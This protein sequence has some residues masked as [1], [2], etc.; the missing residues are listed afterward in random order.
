VTDLATRIQG[1]VAV[2]GDVHGQTDKLQTV[3]DKLRALPDYQ[4][5][6]LVFIGDFV[7]R[8]TDPKGAVDQFLELLETHPRTTAICG[9]HECA[10]GSSLGWIP[11]PDAESWARRWT[12]HYDAESTFES[13]GVEHGGLDELNAAVPEAH[14]ELLT[15]LPWCVEHP[16]FLFVHAGLDPL[17]PFDMQL[18]ILKRK[19]HTLNRPQWLFSKSFVEADPP[20]DCPFTVVSGH[21]RMPKVVIRPKRV[22]VDTTGGLDGDLSCVLLPEKTVISSSQGRQPV[23]ATIGG[24]QPKSWWKMFG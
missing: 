13:Y 7:D 16:E 3:L 10:M 9:N 11:T 23:A 22:L 2:I 5:R 14:R 19:D 15:N 24:E 12:E 6:W 20:K 21:V 18:R 1:P 8:G 17:A 4:K